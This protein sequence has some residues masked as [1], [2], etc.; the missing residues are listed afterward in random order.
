MVAI[1][2]KPVVRLVAV[3]MQGKSEPLREWG[4]SRL[5]IRFIADDFYDELL[6]EVF[7]N[8]AN[9]DLRLPKK[10]IRADAD[11]CWI[12]LSCSGSVPETNCFR[13][14]TFFARI[15]N[16]SRSRAAV[17]ERCFSMGVGTEPGGRQVAHEGTGSA[18]SSRA[19]GCLNSPYRFSTGS[20]ERYCSSFIGI[21][22][23]A[24]CWLKLSWKGSTWP[25]PSDA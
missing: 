21:P 18:R 13:Q 8:S 5:G 14:T 11:S 24:C 20:S 15:G 22:R 17:F 3:P 4:Q 2:G 23:I 1:V 19:S 10:T 6:P 16:T 12:R 7:V 25:R 9:D